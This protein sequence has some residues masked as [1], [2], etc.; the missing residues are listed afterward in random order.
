MRLIWNKAKD[1][2]LLEI[3]F[4]EAPMLQPYEKIRNQVIARY[5]EGSRAIMCDLTGL[6]FIDET[7]PSAF[8]ACV[9][10]A[11]QTNAAFLV[12][13]PHS[14]LLEALEKEGTMNI[15]PFRWELEKALEDIDDALGT[16]NPMESLV[17]GN[18]T[19]FRPSLLVRVDR[20]MKTSGR[21]RRQV[22]IPARP[23]S[24]KPVQDRESGRISLDD[25]SLDEVPKLSDPHQPI[26]E[27]HHPPRKMP[28]K[29]DNEMQEDWQATLELYHT[30]KMLAEK[31]EFD[32]DGQMSFERFTA[33]M[34]AALHM[35]S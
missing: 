17:H 3:D 10:L 23:V 21:G 26:E 20:L 31:Y 33:L 27:E 18:S 12:L 30:A 29:F 15:L 34:S 1:Y 13:N 4:D 5:R 35:R 2:D 25:L 14:I 6:H 28:V 8:A 11:R 22:E 7:A 32:F 19:T 9:R 24:D 16:K